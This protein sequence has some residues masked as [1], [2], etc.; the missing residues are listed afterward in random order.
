LTEIRERK[1]KKRG[2]KE[3]RKKKKGG[4]N[5]FKSVRDNG[6]KGISARKTGVGGKEKIT[7]IC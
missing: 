4:Q 5:I 1:K 7:L 3:K 6:P 2:K